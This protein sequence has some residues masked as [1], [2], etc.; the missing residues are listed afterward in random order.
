MFVLPSLAL[1]I[2]MALHD[3][4]VRVFNDGMVA[5]QDE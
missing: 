3:S 4:L 1:N 5:G 2:S